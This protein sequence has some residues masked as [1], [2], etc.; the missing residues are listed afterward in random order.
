[1]GKGYVEALNHLFGMNQASGRI[2]EL[3]S[4]LATKVLYL[5]NSTPG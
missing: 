2:L 5:K 4:I 1:V 3:S